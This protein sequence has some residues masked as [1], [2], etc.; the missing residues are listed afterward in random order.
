[1]RQYPIWNRIA[2]CI[3]QSDKSYG[4]KETSEV[5]VLVGSSSSNSHEFVRHAT[6][7]RIY[8]GKVVF[9]FYVDEIKIKRMIF[10]DNDG[11]A[12]NLIETI[13]YLNHEN[14]QNL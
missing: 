4:A 8:D 7:K 13:N 10:E 3:Y 12:G 14:N 9:T 6:T 1:M 11:R 2:A 5:T